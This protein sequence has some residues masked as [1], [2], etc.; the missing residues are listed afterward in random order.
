MELPR[1][2]GP[3]LTGDA[4]VN[5]GVFHMNRDAESLRH[6]NSAGAW[7]PTIFFYRWSRPT[8]TYGH[9]LDGKKATAWAKKQKIAAVVRRPTGGGAVLHRPNDL[10]LSILWPRYLKLFPDRPRDC[11]TAIHRVLKRAVDRC[12]HKGTTLYLKPGGRCQTPTDA[13]RKTLPVCFQEPVCS[14]VM[15]EG[16]KIVGGA[17]R[18]SKKAVLYQGTFQLDGVSHRVLQDAITDELENLFAPGNS[19]NI[20]IALTN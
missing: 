13:S 14:D 20:S 8:I 5:T 12:I 6:L 17:L 11:Y 10:S 9:L 3:F 16:R 15:M 1:M 7:L 18:L 4:G 2:I 19:K